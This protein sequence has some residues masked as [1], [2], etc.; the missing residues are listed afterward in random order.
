MKK[1]GFTLIEMIV[2]LAIISIMAATAYPALKGYR[3]RG[4]EQERANQEYVVNK[5][6][7]Q[8]YALVGLYPVAR[9]VDGSGAILASE[10]AVFATDIVA[11][12][13]VRPDTTKYRFRYP[14][15]DPAIPLS[16]PTNP[17]D[18]LT[19]PDE[20]KKLDYTQI[21]VVLR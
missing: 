10:E 20:L 14:L 7:K 18:P 1:N 8:Y 2:V 21:Q 9:A 3:D 5:A 17:S 15:E 13:G 11:K 4:I 19:D 6:F 12:T 16:T